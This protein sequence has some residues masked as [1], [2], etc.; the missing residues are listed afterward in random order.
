MRYAASKRK[1]SRSCKM[2]R[3]SHSNFHSNLTSHS[4][5]SNDPAS[6]NPATIYTRYTLPQPMYDNLC[7]DRNSLRESK[8][9]RKTCNIIQRSK[10]GMRVIR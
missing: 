5:L 9:K 6:V 2:K 8:A 7:Q 1:A 10:G 4:R 3:A